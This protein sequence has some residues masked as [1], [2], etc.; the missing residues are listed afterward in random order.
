MNAYF[1]P[2]LL[3]SAVLFLFP[4]SVLA[5]SDR[6]SFGVIADTFNDTQNAP[7]L[8]TAISESD[9]DNLAFVVVNGIKSRME[10]C[11]DQL[12]N[13]RR[14]L[15]DEAENGL[16]LS[17][18]ASDWA[19]CRR[20]D[21]KSAAIERL[22]RLRDLFFTGEFSFGSTRIPLIRQSLT[23]KFR[24]YGENT[25]WMIHDAMFAT[26]NL[27]ANNNNYLAAAGRNS[28]FEDRLVANRVWLQKLFKTATRKKLKAIVIFCD[29]N[30]LSKTGSQSLF[31]RTRNRDGFI[32]I[33]RQISTLGSKFPG[34]VLIVHAQEKSDP[35]ERERV[36]WRS[37]VGRLGVTPGWIKVTIDPSLPA[38]FSVKHYPAIPRQP[39][40]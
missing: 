1:L 14:S 11:T 35:S 19:D 4:C 23:P 7:S 32:E 13:R 36:H 40:R 2:G 24:S 38:L 16:I 10:P 29:G 18:A 28:E 30:P 37:N 39:A 20:N 25:R 27:P 12:Y 6:L 34:K 5:E 31:G 15:F 33:R 9:A 22:N 26:V 17:L 21:G 3:A 8:R